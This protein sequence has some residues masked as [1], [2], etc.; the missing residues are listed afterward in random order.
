MSQEKYTYHQL[1][2]MS[3]DEQREYLKTCSKDELFAYL[4]TGLDDLTK[5]ID[6]IP[7]LIYDGMEA[8]LPS[9]AESK[10]VSEDLMARLRGAR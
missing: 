9:H 4:H 7:G 2:H 8:K 5:Q 1:K 10:Q 3:S 6:S